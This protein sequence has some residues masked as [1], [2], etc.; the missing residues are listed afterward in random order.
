M[1]TAIPTDLG[2][3]VVLATGAVALLV[4]TTDI[5]TTGAILVFSFVFVF[6][7]CWFRISRRWIYA[8]NHSK[9]RP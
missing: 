2:E 6:V 9:G 3:A 1:I 8:T 4:V 7:L 5:D